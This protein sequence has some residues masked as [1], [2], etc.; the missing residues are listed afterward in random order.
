[1]NRKIT[2]VAMFISALTIVLGA[3]G[4]HALEKIVPPE[5]V[6]SYEVGVQY[7]MY[8]SIALLILGL[9]PLADTYRNRIFWIFLTGIICFSGSIYL[10]TFKTHLN[11]EVGKLGLI[12][13][14][15]GILFIIGWI[16]WGL[17]ILRSKKN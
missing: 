17:S 8:H 16:Y 5:S 14:L 15:G 2:A 12:T 1:M 10:F 4:A 13:P 11:F 6:A 3:F 9:M 7:Q